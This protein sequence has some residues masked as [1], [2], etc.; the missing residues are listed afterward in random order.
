MQLGDLSS[1]PAILALGGTLLTAALLVRR[2]R[3][4]I[5]IG[6]VATAFA[7]GMTG[8]IQFGEILSLPPS[9]APTLLKM[10]I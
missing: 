10:G 5:L 3:G 4:A 8:Y 2:V 1:A 6:L 7:G 9:L